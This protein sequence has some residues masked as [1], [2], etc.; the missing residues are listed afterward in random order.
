MSSQ[1][2]RVLITG[3][4]GF[5]GAH[6]A[7]RFLAGGWEVVLF[8]LRPPELELPPAFPRAVEFVQGN[9][10]G[11]DELA[12][13]I[14]AHSINGIVHSAAV[15]G[16][17]RAEEQPALAF[18]INVRGTFN[19]L[20]AARLRNLRFTYISTA[21]LYGQK[22]DREPVR[23]SDLPDPVGMYDGT[24]YMGEVLAHSYHKAY[25]VDAVSLRPGFLYGPGSNIGH[26]YLD[27]LVR[28]ESLRGVPGADHYCDFTYIKD[29]AE[30]VYLAHTTRP[31]ANRV[32]NISS[33]QYFSRAHFA[34]VVAT[35][36]GGDVE[37][38]LGSGLPARAHQRGPSDNSRAAAEFGYEPRYDLEAGLRDWLAWLRKQESQ[39]VR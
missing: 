34:K 3:G 28:G 20:E 26:Y 15:V 14:S 31:L 30:G 21:T 32:F 12:E 19:A 17:V 2:G 38:K 16:D 11:V 27:R 9:V 33:R 37:I 35:V 36:L 6:I 10:L 8:D 39:G 13:A 22:E 29:F 25:A 18:D 24:K 4:S 7:N 23:E 1:K 5:V